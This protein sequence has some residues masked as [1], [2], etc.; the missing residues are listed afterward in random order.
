MILH[1]CDP[2]IST[3]THTCH[4]VC[5]CEVHAAGSLVSDQWIST[6]HQCFLLCAARRWGGTVH[7]AAS[8]CRPTRA[9]H[10][11]H[12]HHDST[13]PAACRGGQAQCGPHR[14]NRRLAF[15]PWKVGRLRIAVEGST[16]DIQRR[17]SC[18]RLHVSFHT[19]GHSAYLVCGSRRLWRS[20]LVCMG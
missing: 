17:R 19:P 2:I 9:G 11:R 20:W 7:A 16:G 13:S 15:R 1:V 8:G 14:R 5:Q 18:R 3:R 10:R 6:R 12:Q 4:L